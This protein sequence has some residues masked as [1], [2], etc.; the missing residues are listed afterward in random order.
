M[1]ACR[2]S[3][4]HLYKMIKTIPVLLVIIPVWSVISCTPR[5]DN[6]ITIS[7][8][9]QGTTYHISYLPADSV[10]ISGSVDSLLRRIDS[11]LSTYLPVSLVSRINRNEKGVE[12]DEHFIRVFHKSEEV[13]ILTNGAF[14]I[15]VAPLVNA[16]GFGFSRK[17]AVDSLVIDNLLGM[18][19]YEKIKLLKRSGHYTVVKEKPGMMIDFNA[20]AQGYTVDLL[21][22]LLESHRIGVY[23]IELGGEVKAKGSKKNGQ[24]WRV[25]IDKPEEGVDPGEELQ[26]I[27]SLQDEALATSGNYRKFYESGGQKYSHII[28]PHTGYPAKN[29]LLSASVVAQN[30]M[31]ADAFATAFMVMG[32]EKSKQFLEENRGLGLE[33]F[34]VYDEQGTWKNFISGGLKERL[35]ELN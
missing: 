13:S 33:V 8:D 35:E 2:N 25:G 4:M 32:L 23:F 21:A 19:G 31:T 18:T 3:G 24:H 17:A 11:S 15:T 14:D 26:A 29:N 27:L 20:I 5:Q 9:A 22:D 12:P 7:G 6:I 16:W 28:D 34:F 1:P 30:C 10:D